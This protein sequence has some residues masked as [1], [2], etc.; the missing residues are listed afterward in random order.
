MIHAKVAVGKR[1][2]RTDFGSEEYAECNFSHTRLAGSSFAEASF[3][4]CDFTHADF[5][6]ST[7]RLSC[8]QGS[9]NKLDNFGASAFLY[10]L[11]Q[12]FDLSSE[13]RRDINNIVAPYRPKLE[14]LFRREEP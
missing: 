4:R 10:W 14:L 13:M 3:V 9:G 1:L 8:K 11:D 7:F 6:D 5:F 2:E 12:V